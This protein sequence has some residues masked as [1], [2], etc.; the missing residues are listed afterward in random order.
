MDMVDMIQAVK[1]VPVE[2]M[3]QGDMMEVAPEVTVRT[4]RMEDVVVLIIPMAVAVTVTTQ[5]RTI[6]MEVAVIRI[7]QIPITRMAVVVILTTR[8]AVAV[9]LTILMEDVAVLTT[10]E[11]AQETMDL[12]ATQGWEIH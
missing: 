1:E 9:I 4:I 7:T 5:I 2:D 10:P 6:R 8:M 12:V 3:I 11:E